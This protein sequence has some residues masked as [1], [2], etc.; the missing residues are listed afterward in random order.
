VLG[1]TV[2][3]LLNGTPAHR[4]LSQWELNHWLAFDR[5]QPIGDARNEFHT[6]LLAS[7][8][9][10]MAGKVM[11]AG[12]NVSARDFMPLSLPKADESNAALVESLLKMGGTIKRIQP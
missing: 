9:T 11:P 4:A 6:A 3:E 2:D 12:R 10:N 1:R 7:T 5:V 8:M